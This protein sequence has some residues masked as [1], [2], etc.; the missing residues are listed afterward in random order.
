MATIAVTGGKGGTGKSTVACSLAYELSKRKRVMLIDADVDCPNDHLLLSIERKHVKDVTAFLPE[1]DHN[2]CIACGKCAQACRANAIVHVPG[3][4]PIFVEQQCIGCRAC[5]IV[6][7]AGAI[8]E[9]AKKIGVVYKGKKESL[10]FFSAELLPGFEESSPVV[11]ALKEVAMKNADSY[12]YIIIDTA[13][14]THCNVISA[15]L[16]CDFAIAVTEPTPLGKHD[17][18]LIL[19]LLSILRIKSGIVINRSD[20]ADAKVIEKSA[21]RFNVPIIEKIPY[22]KYIEENYAKGKPIEDE[23]IKK[24][25]NFLEAS[26]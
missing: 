3:K 17:L 25:A 6:C 9:S 4:K 15:L 21:K 18:E 8:K 12:D 19:E 23:A 14:G 20:I 26:L 2:K 5:Q 22:S 10:D 11:N 7:P 24:L 13:A 16:G 1:F